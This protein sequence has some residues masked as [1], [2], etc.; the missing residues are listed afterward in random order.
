MVHG[1]GRGAVAAVQYQ[2][3]RRV[4]PDDRVFDKEVAG[5][6]DINANSAGKAI[7]DA[8]FNMKS[9]TCV[10]HNTVGVVE[11]LVIDR[12]PPQYHGIA[13]RRRVYGYGGSCRT[14][15]AR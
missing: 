15:R 5:T 9:S 1:E 13:A 10:E 2:D 6:G 8:I 7:H 14:P 12:Q 11:G 4:S 3:S